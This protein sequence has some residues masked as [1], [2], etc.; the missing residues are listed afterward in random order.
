MLPS[1][2]VM[3]V[4]FHD[5]DNL[6]L[7]YLASSLLA[8]GHQVKLEVFGAN[9]GPL[10]QSAVD[11][12]PDVIGFSLIFQFMVPEFATAIR[13]LREAK[14]TAHITMGGHYASFA[15]ET[16]LE[17][18]P[19]LDSVVRFEGERTIV[20]LAEAVAGGHLWHEIHGIAWRST[21]GVQLTP[22]RRDGTALDDL[23]WPER[24]DIQYESQTIPTAS[25]L[26]SRG[27]PF[28]CSFCSIITFYQGNGTPGR[29]RR[30]PHLVVDELEHLV[31]DRGVRLVLFQDDD[32]I[33]GG[34]DARTW[35][36]DVCDQIISRGLHRRLRFK[37]SCRSDEV[38]DDV[39][40][41]LIRAGLAHVY[42]G[43]ESGDPDSLKTLNKRI[44]PD[45]HVRAGHVLRQL[46]ITFDFGFM[47]LEPWSTIETVRNNLSFLRDYSQDGYTTAGFCRTLPYVGTPLETRL[48]QE[49]RLVGPALEADYQFLDPRLDAL[50][51][52]SLVAFAGRNYGPNAT[53]NS[54]RNLLFEA[55]LDYPDRPHDP[56]FRRAAQRLSARSNE[57]LI[58]VTEEA[59]ARI[60]AM[61][62]PTASDP[63]LMRLAQFSIEQNNQVKGMLDAL[64]AAKPRAIAAE[65]FR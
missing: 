45:V 5:Q 50:W 25:V 8:A 29:R 57:L 18:I 58:E 7:R 47:L 49:G 55:R 11:W 63:G 33:A 23:P 42:L 53:W 28:V 44:T 21:E 17:L 14:V 12:K 62:E 35:V 6:G 51:D 43:V 2:R 34:A 31:R 48:R 38:R 61:H 10:V 4:G 32:F 15:P 13:N 59:I 22:A 19:D 40:E 9:P 54:L 26:A 46:D 20:E 65:L 64:R 52:F 37:I 24:S 41:P 16:L 1:S 3:L 60:D 30:N 39:L 27:C 36:L 56:Q